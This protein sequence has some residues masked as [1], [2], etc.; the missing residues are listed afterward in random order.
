[1]N[2]KTSLPAL[3]LA[4]L[5]LAAGSPSATANVTASLKLPLS[6]SLT[7]DLAFGDII[8]VDG[9]AG[10]VKVSPT[11]ATTT[12]GGLALGTTNPGAPLQAQ[13]T[14]TGNVAYDL[15]FGT[16]IQM[17]DKAG[18]GA[19]IPVLALEVSQGG[20]AVSLNPGT[21]KYSGTT[22]KSGT[23][24]LLVGAT[25]TVA[26]SQAPGNYAGTFQVTVAYQ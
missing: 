12:T 7:S 10:T 20:I 6:L 9:T 22:D 14:S 13:F 3:F 11:E 16:N 18:I 21:G 8:L 24:L 26:A 5:P 2:L 1:M 25:M 19:P 17:T 4:A 15:T 23:T